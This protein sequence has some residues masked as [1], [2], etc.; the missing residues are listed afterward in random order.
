MN[1]DLNN[2]NQDNYN[3]QGNN[4]IS[5]GKPLDSQ[6]FNQGMNFSQQPI[7]TQ[8]Q[9]TPS[10]SQ[11]NMQ[12]FAP[13]PMNNTFESENSSNQYS[14]NKTPKKMNLGLIIGIVIIAVIVVIGV[15][16]GGKIFS[17]GNGSSQTINEN[18]NGNVKFVGSY[19]NLKTIDYDSH[20]GPQHFATD[21][22]VIDITGKTLISADFLNRQFLGDDYYIQEKDNNFVVIKDD[23]EI[24]SYDCNDGDLYC[25]V[26]YNKGIIYYTTK[27]NSKR[28][29]IAYDLTNRKELWKVNG[30]TPFVLANGNIVVESVDSRFYDIIDKDGNV[31]AS[32]VYPTATSIYFK[33]SIGSFEEKVE[34]YDNNK[35]I[36]ELTVREFIS[37]LSNGM[38]V[39]RESG[40]EWRYG[41]YDKD[42]KLITTLDDC[43]K[44][45]GSVLGY[46]NIVSVPSVYDDSKKSI[47]SEA[48]DF[49][50]VIIYNDGTIEKLYSGYSETGK[51]DSLIINFRTKNYLVGYEQNNF[52]VRKIINLSN[53][54]SKTASEEIWSKSFY[55][56][57]NGKYIILN[58]GWEDLKKRRVLDE[59]LDLI[60][61]T[62]NELRPVNDS[63]VI[64]YSLNNKS[65]IYLVNVFTKEKTKLDTKG[66]YLSNNAVGLITTSDGKYNLYAFN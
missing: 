58:K 19:D 5:D 49:D 59:N 40:T 53:G 66:N 33:V 15:I 6:N 37:P 22:Q 36:N 31:I 51:I 62:D 34:I 32:S 55:E 54:K 45:E 9:Q 10:F 12:E 1:Q 8:P 29:V 13:K 3:A 43:S 21:N 35:K 44:F 7:N 47:I 50:D 64:E 25:G 60:Y 63:F 41:V 20:L 48:Q 4:G 23:K 14:D 16:F 65:E 38:F 56:S 39:V 2:L 17:K 11:Q 26:A 27:E 46:L 30:N 24:L 61:E 52:D 57:L 42:L 28:I 18:L